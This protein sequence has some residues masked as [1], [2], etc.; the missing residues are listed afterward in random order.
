MR[1]H[2]V[3]LANHDQDS[4]EAQGTSF[5]AGLR[6]HGTPRRTASPSDRLTE[7]RRDRAA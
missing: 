3:I 5:A 4:I 7:N 6:D 1:V 2:R